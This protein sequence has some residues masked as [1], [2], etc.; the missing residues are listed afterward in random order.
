M[1]RLSYFLSIAGVF[2]V[3]I[4]LHFS[5]C[6]ESKNSTLLDTSG[7]Q[8]ATEIAVSSVSGAVASSNGTLGAMALRNQTQDR[9]VAILD[10]IENSAN[11][12]TACPTLQSSF[13]SC[14]SGV[15]TLTYSSCQMI[16]G[17]GNYN[18]VSWDGSQVIFFS[19]GTCPASFSAIKSGNATLTRTF[20]PGTTRTTP[21]GMVVTLNTSIATGYS[22][23]VSGGT[24]VAMTD[25]VGS[26]TIT[27]NGIQYTA[28]TGSG[29]V[30]WDHSV[31]T[32]TS[33]I[34]TAPGLGIA[35]GTIT[36]GT[37]QVQH[38]LAKYTA[39]AAFNSVTYNH[40]VCGCF[41]TGGTITTTLTGS[42]TGTETLVITGCAKATLTANDG[43]TSTVS[44]THCL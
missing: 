12:T 6:S 40:G 31:S 26:R 2:I 16:K 33:L 20:G 23:H 28:T 8:S 11:A 18:G 14:S 37:V 5:G 25:G 9:W 27:I 1:K 22:F 10:A 24:T 30:A 13:P 42:Q 21:D 41:P 15:V 4:A 34:F 17:N 38:N 32:T 19:G 7:N 3:G 39:S 43:T 35:T 36:S 29:T 44:L